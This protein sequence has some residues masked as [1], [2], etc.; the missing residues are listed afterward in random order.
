MNEVSP[1]LLNDLISMPSLRSWDYCVEARNEAEARQDG[2]SQPT[3]KHLHTGL[4]HWDIWHIQ[5]SELMTESA[6]LS[7][8]AKMRAHFGSGLQRQLT[9]LGV[10]PPSPHRTRPPTLYS[11]W[12]C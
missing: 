3:L 11:V 5:N 1:V 8:V 10:S 6:D 7:P 9:T 12:E 2:D 4:A